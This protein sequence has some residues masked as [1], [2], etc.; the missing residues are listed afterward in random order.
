MGENLAAF[1]Q[2]VFSA[3]NT[4][5]EAPLNA[6]ADFLHSEFDPKK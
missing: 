4:V 5:A 3:V 2:D 1:T 6:W